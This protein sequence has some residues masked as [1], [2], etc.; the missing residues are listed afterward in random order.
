MSRSQFIHLILIVGALVL[1]AVYLPLKIWLTALFG[2]SELN[3]NLAVLAFFMLIIIGMV[4]MF[5]VSLQAMAAGLIFGLG[6]G[7]LVMWL[8]GLLGFTVA[9]L[10]GRGLAR[11]WVERWV[12]RRPGFAVMEQAINQ[13]GLIIVILARLAQVL[14]YNLL[15]YFFGLTS[16]NLKDYV[17][18]SAVGMVPGIFMFVFIGTTATDIA[19]ILSREL[20]LGDYELWIAGFGVL[21][22]AALVVLITLGA[23]RALGSQMGTLEQRQPRE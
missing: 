20:T 13:K 15:N 11:P 8:G 14:P 9:F 12:S 23:R 4:L 1:L 7:F 21:M 17:L 19:A 22:V 3:P 6:K 5:P 18:G 10:A 2:W 16:V